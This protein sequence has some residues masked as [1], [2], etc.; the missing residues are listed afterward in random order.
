MIEI[1][2]ATVHLTKTSR[3]NACVEASD[4]GI[5]PGTAPRT[6]HLINNGRRT[7]FSLIGVKREEGEVEFWSYGYT[8]HRGE[9][10]TLTVFND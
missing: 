2:T 3:N 8:N 4:I 6:V 1:N 5:A 9:R 10:F 7:E